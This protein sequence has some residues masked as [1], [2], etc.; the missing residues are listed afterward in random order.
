GEFSIGAGSSFTLSQPITGSGGLLMIGAGT[1]ILSGATSYSGATTVAAGVLDF[2][3]AQ[4]SNAAKTMTI[5]IGATLQYAVASGVRDETDGTYSGGGTLLKTGAGS[6]RWGGGVGTFDLD[7]GSLIDVQGGTLD[8]GA[9][10]NEVW[11]ANH[12]SLN[13]AAGATITELN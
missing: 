12:S 4:P 8:A 6:L 7:Y 1:L 2:A 13:V 10:G 11:S 9:N 3:G 5:E